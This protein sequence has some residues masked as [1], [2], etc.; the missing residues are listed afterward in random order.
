[1]ALRPVCSGS[2]TERALD[3]AG[4]VALDRPEL[5]GLDRA[6]AV[7][8]QAERVDD[9]ADQRLADRHLGDPVGALDGVAFLDD[10]V[11]AEEH[12][13]DLVLLEVEHHADDVAGELQELAGHRLLE[14]V[15]ARDAVADL[16]DATDLLQVDLRLVARQLALDDLADLSGLD[17]VCLPYPR[18]SRCRMRAS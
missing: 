18:A 14:P 7:D 10:A 15:D 6:L 5:R 13:A 2:L 12:G 8:R 17:H 3:H 1:M 16:D 4:R 9:A 11:V